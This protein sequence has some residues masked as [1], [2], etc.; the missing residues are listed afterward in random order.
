MEF[1]SADL[2]QVFSDCFFVRYRTLLVGGGEEPLYVPSPVPA[3]TPHRIVYREDYF[4]SAL[5][6]VAHWCLAGADRRRR[7]DYGY[8]YAPDGR[9]AEEQAAFER[10]EARPQALEW[11]LSE[12]CG[13]EFNLS[14]DNLVGGE[15]PSPSFVEEVARE[16]SSLLEGGL[17]DRAEC[18]RA[19]LA[20]KL[21]GARSSDGHT[22]TAG[23]R[24]NPP[25]V[26]RPSER[27]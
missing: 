11:I 7:E 6:E 16:K 4:A 24:S 26:D 9:G 8:W 1:E 17:P 18:F 19:A 14:A 15:G 5:H 21:S 23:E 13:F 12:S 20:T 2:E 27:A 25:S 22:I 3:D 10:A